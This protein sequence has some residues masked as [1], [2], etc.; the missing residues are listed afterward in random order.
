VLNHQFV[1]NFHEAFPFWTCHLFELAARYLREVGGK[2]NVDFDETWREIS[3]WLG[4]IEDVWGVWRAEKGDVDT[5][6]EE[7]GLAGK[8]C[9]PSLGYLHCSISSLCSRLE[10]NMR[11]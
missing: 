3:S 2:G 7:K 4:R 1:F 8:C 5:K 6:Y 9:I 11:S 10:V